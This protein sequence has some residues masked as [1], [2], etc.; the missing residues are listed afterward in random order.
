MDENDI[1]GV[2]E[3]VENQIKF[4]QLLKQLAQNQANLAKIDAQIAIKEGKTVIN[5]TIDSTKREL[6]E[7]A[8]EFGINLR[9]IEE[10]YKKAKADRKE[11]IEEYKDE[12]FE[13]DEYYQRAMQD[14]LEKK[15]ELEADE[16]EKM[17]D[18]KKN[19]IDILKAQK[20]Y[21]KD[22][23]EFKAKANQ[24]IKDGKVSELRKMTSEWE[25][26]EKNN[27]IDKLKLERVQLET[28]KKKIRS[29]INKCEEIFVASRESRKSTIMDLK[30]EK[31]NKLAKIPKQNVIQKIIGSLFSKVNGTKK[32][33]RT[34]F[35]PLKAKIE[36]IKEEDIPRIK[37]DI[38][39]KRQE[40][41]DKIKHAK[42]NIVDNVQEKVEEYSN[43]ILEEKQ[44]A[45]DAIEDIK[46]EAINK[47][48]DIG[49]SAY[50]VKENIIQNIKDTKASIMEKVKNTKEKVSTKINATVDSGKRTF[51]KVIEHGLQIKMNFINKLQ[52]KLYEQQ[53]EIA[54]K[55][56]KLNPDL[57]FEKETE[58]QI[59]DLGIDE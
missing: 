51:R 55:M 29:L 8:K 20:K 32:F 19:K 22:I 31:N 44:K 40:F 54:E 4:L 27:P 24:L 28:E 17:Y 37:N 2:K 13:I 36:T 10:K 16:Q 15:E 34:T 50:E 14:I 7:K 30:E 58:E 35:E 45:I 48:E 23:M 1:E 12:L 38:S 57:N 49:Q 33:M 46:M 9:N 59:E 47:A 26:F 42:E 5:E 52:N 18:L 39:E 41:S 11:I 3:E 25:K 56:K 53:N 6:E 43:K 21:D